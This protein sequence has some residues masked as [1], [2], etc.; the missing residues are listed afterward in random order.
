MANQFG[1]SRQDEES[2]RARDKA[3][4]YCRKAM[5]TTKELKSGIGKVGD[6]ASIEH[7]NFC[8][9]FYIKDGLRLD[10]IV[11]CCGSCNSSRRDRRLWDWFRFD[12]CV[13]RNI[14]VDTVADPVR[15]YLLQMPTELKD[16]VKSCQWKSA[17]KHADT[18]PHEYIVCHEVGPNLFNS[19]AHHI[20]SHGYVASFYENRQTY[21]DCCCGQT[22][23][24]IKNIINRCLTSETY[25]RREHQGRLP[26]GYAIYTRNR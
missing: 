25:E 4:V 7:L 1:I 21:W 15:K 18:W 12:Y 16:F 17:Q 24:Q 22:Y 9:P 14:N 13:K 20:E 19:L 6:R 11:I 8:G 23:W 3:C 5:R 10:D 2:I 26:I